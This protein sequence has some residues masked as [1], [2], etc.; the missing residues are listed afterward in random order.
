MKAV[1]MVM[2]II[3]KILTEN[4]CLNTYYYPSIYMNK[5]DTWKF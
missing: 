2:E 5:A 3:T 1:N 4:I